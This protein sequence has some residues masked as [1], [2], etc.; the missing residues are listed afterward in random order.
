MGSLSGRV[1]LVTGAS[2]GIGQ[3]IAELFAREGALV[4]CTARTLEEG[5]HRLF[6]GSLRRTVD[7][8]R[9]AG[10]QAVA[11][12]CDVSEYDNCEALVQEVRSQLG[13][14]D[15]LV[16]NAALTYFIPIADYPVGSR[17]RVKRCSAAEG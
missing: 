11:L 16:N 2:R 8:I 14:I 4:A 6:E 12:P 5:D 17:D 15:L 7:R 3:E 13:P 1:A 10:G 9:D